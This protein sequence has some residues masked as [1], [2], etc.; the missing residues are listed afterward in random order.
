MPS[1]NLIDQRWIPCLM[2]SGRHAELGL[3]EVLARAPD[4]REIFDPSPLVVAGLHRLLL[5]ILHRNFGPADRKEWKALWG[6]GRWDE[7]RLEGYFARWHHRFDLFDEQRPFYQVPEMTDAK[8]HPVQ[9]L[10]LE[11]ASGNNA[12]LFDHS[13]ADCPDALTPAQAARCLIARQNFSIGFGKSQPFYFQDAPLVRGYSVLVAGNN[14]FETLALNLIP[15]NDERPMKRRGDDLPAWER[16]DL[17]QPDPR[18]TPLRGYLDYLTWQSRRIH[19]F[20]DDCEP[21]RVRHCQ[22]QQG[23]RLPDTRPPDPF[24]PYRRDEQRGFVPVPINPDKALWRDSHALFAEEGATS[25]R[26]EV[27]SWLAQLRRY[28]ELPAQ[29]RYR[30]SLIGLATDPGKAASLLLWR[31]ECL[32]LP[33]AYLEDKDLRDSLREALG[34]AE[35]VKDVLAG[36]VRHLAQL[37]LCPE[38][39]RGGRKPLRDDVQAVVRRLGPERQYWPRLE[40]PFRRLLEELPGDAV[41]EADGLTYGG[42]TLPAWRETLR[43]AATKS[44]EAIA[45]GLEPTPRARKAV[46]IAEGEFKRRLGGI[47][48]KPGVEVRDEQAA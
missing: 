16:D 43:R 11:A 48:K 31:Q 33:L 42:R 14:L 2:R 38:S 47:L 22:L 39:D 40:A 4:V 12:T 17:P 30:F 44:F 9:L 25:Q 8:R 28:G 10:T 46:A 45:L 26:P 18:G 27:F 35:E 21:V 36:S 1:F 32:P 20:P 37:T 41:Q 29:A 19:L 24:K 15:Y 34:L 3:G 7:A 13:L 23:L 6:Q 5:A